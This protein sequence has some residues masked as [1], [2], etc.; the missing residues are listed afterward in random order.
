MIKMIM[1]MSTFNWNVVNLSVLI[2]YYLALHQLETLFIPAV[3]CVYALVILNVT[4]LVRK[5]MES[6]HRKTQREN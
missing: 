2:L 4:K 6:Y 1:G 3:I 5:L